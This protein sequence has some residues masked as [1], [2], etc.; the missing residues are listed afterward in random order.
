[1]TFRSGNI[2]DNFTTD[3]EFRLLATLV[4]DHFVA[5]GLVQTADSGQI[6]LASV[7]KPAA[8]TTVAGYEVWRFDDTLAGS[9]PIYFK[10]EYASN[11][12]SANNA[13]FWITVGTGSDGAGTITSTALANA[14]TV[15]ARKQISV[16]TTGAASGIVLPC[17]FDYM[18]DGTG[19]TLAMW[20]SATSALGGMGFGIERIRD[21]DGSATSDGFNMFY[22]AQTTT[23]GTA[24]FDGRMFLAGSLQP[25][26]QISL[27]PSPQLTLAPLNTSAV[28]GT[29]L[30]PWPVFTG[31]LPRL[32]G[33]SQLFFG[34]GRND[35][36][37]GVTFTLPHYGTSH[38]WVSLGAGGSASG[39]G[40][41]GA[42]S[43][44]SSIAMRAD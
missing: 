15:Q 33:P 41:V 20:P 18:S 43:A 28:M 22:F 32:G 1:M 10:I 13:A 8:I 30:Y 3:A 9:F 6:N 26:V 37:T 5:A 21:Y 31:V 12:T 24:G 36:A 25:T 42:S 27:W 16:A 40:S 19:F 35:L 44:L 34:L 17:Y 29:T 11:G 2:K 4:H 38:T 7:V 39:W 23:T 14:G